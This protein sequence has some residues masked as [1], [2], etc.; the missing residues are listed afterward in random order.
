MPQIKM[1]F[2]IPWYHLT[3]WRD[4]SEIKTYQFN[5]SEIVIFSTSKFLTLCFLWKVKICNALYCV[6]SFYLECSLC[7]LL[8]L[9]LEFS[10][11]ILLVEF[12]ILNWEPSHTTSA[13]DQSL[14]HKSH[15]WAAQRKVLAS[16]THCQ[17]S[18]YPCTKQLMWEL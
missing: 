17:I 3:F 15:L 16:S 9:L 11:S 6:V 5:L 7:W 4:H 10:I 13:P 14:Q 12:W 18:G 2:K 1:N 8:T